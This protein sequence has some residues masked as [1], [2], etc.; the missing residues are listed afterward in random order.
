MYRLVQ[1]ASK[2]ESE[3]II[4]SKNGAA[5]VLLSIDEYEAWKE[6]AEILAIP[7]ASQEIQQGNRE[8][9]LRQGSKWTSGE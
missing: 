7:N 9:R 1:S 5:A 4:Q 8:A 2:G 3:Y 6:T